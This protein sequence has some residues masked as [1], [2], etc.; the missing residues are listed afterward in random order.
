MSDR[1]TEVRPTRK[2]LSTCM[3]R[4]AALIQHWH[5]FREHLAPY[6][7]Y[8]L[9]VAASVTGLQR[10]HRMSVLIGTGYRTTKCTWVKSGLDRTG[11]AER[12]RHWTAICI[13]DDAVMFHRKR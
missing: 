1:R 2:N 6:N 12:S 13:A 10:L 7:V 9:I 5:S 11:R 8:L 4:A 3:A